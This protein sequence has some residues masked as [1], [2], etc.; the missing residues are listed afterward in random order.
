M[1]EGFRGIDDRPS[2]NSIP[3][4][5]DMVNFKINEDGSLQK[6]CGFLPVMSFSSNLRAVWSGKLDGRERVYVI[7][8][9]KVATVDPDTLYVSDIGSIR[10]QSGHANFIFFDANLYVKDSLGFYLIS[11]DEVRKVEGYAPLYAKDWPSAAVGE[12]NE[13]PNL[14]S[15]RIRMSYIVTEPN[16]YLRVEHLLSSVDAVYVNGIRRTDENSYYF[17]SSLMCVCVLNIQVGDKVELYLTLDDSEMMSE[18]ADILGCQQ[19]FVYGGSSS[20]RFFLWG[21]SHADVVYGSSDI[22]DT[23][24]EDSKKVYADSMPLYVKENAA[25]PMGREKK[26]ISAVCRHYDRMLIFTADDTWMAKYPAADGEPLDAVTVNSTY[27]CTSD[28]AALMLGNDPI[29]ISKRSILK[30]TSDTD[31]LN[32][33]NAYSISEEIESRLD[34]SFFENAT[35]FAD[36]GTGELYFCDPSDEN[37][38]VWIYASRTK[39]WYKYDGVGAES[40]LEIGDK[41]AF[42]KENTLYIFDPSSTLDILANGEERPITAYFESLPQDVGAAENK[43]RLS[44]M[45]LD[46]EMQNTSL[47]IEYISGDKVI[48]SAYVSA[49]DEPQRHE[50][51]RLNSPR[52]NCLKIKLSSNDGGKLRI[53][54]TGVWTKI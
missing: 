4:A 2:R 40:F 12:M 51:R 54:S 31:E 33:C 13:P 26:R 27:G 32:E 38:V 9:N 47:V 8:S 10:S 28:G 41:V 22:D 49:T 11:S 39:N 5:A 19:A 7:Y 44:G 52:F 18:S 1:F 14:I 21:G 24:L 48:S 20:S 29:C 34:A 43:K 25:F 36:R 3:H 46:A 23:S 30:W 6:R 17:D 45:S 16:I 37:G 35:I 42:T 15:R 50:K 53:F